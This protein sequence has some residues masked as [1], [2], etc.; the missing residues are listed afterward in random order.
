MGPVGLMA[1]Q[2]LSTTVSASRQRVTLK[3]CF[4]YQIQQ[5]VAGQRPVSPTVAMGVKSAHHG[6]GLRIP[7]L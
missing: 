4:Q 3:S 7:V 1:R 2:R 6:L 5:V